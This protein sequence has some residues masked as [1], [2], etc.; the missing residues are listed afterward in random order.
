MRKRVQELEQAGKVDTIPEF[1]PGCPKN[2]AGEYLTCVGFGDGTPSNMD[3]YKMVTFQSLISN[4]AAPQRL[5]N[6]GFLS[7]LKIYRWQ[8]IGMFENGTL[9]EQGL[10]GYADGNLEEIHRPITDEEAR[11]YLLERVPMLARLFGKPEGG[12]Q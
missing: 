7:E 9:F 6:D 8:D 5:A 12:K 11:A 3:D 4:D 10:C 2:G 1:K